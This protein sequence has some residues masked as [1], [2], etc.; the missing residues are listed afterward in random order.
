[1]A[2]G[3]NVNVV[4][5]AYV[6]TQAPIKLYEYLSELGKSV[7]YCD[8]DSVVFLQ[9]DNDPPKVKTGEYLGDLTNE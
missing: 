3:K 4:V 8:T 9:K 1:M 6:T 5:A 7:L 2:T